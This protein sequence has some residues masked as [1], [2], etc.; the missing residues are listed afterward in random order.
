MT[1]R[2]WLSSLPTE[3]FAKMISGGIDCDFC[4]YDDS[5]NCD[6]ECKSNI[7]MWLNKQR[8]E[9]CCRDCKYFKTVKKLVNGDWEYFNICDLFID[10]EDGW[11]IVTTEFD[12][13]ESWKRR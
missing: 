11:G 4:V 3:E 13:C 10:E 9:E 2:E 1:N 12:L 7:L 6:G 8:A 5:K